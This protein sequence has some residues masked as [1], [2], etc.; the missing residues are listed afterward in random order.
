SRTA[1]TIERIAVEAATQKPLHIVYGASNYQWYHGDIEFVATFDFSMTT[2]CQWSDVVFPPPSY[3]A[4]L[5]ATARF[6]KSGCIEFYKDEDLFLVK[7]EQLPVNKPTFADT[8]YRV[9]SWDQ[10]GFYGALA[11]VC[12]PLF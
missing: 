1:A 10:E 5:P 3:P 4:P 8:E 6:V 11:Q 9:V 7:G 2:S 12:Q